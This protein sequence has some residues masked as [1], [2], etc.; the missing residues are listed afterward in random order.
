MKVKTIIPKSEARK[1][2]LQRSGEFSHEDARRKTQA[3]IERLSTLDDFIHA[4][5]V[6]THISRNNWEIDTRRLIDYIMGQGKSVV[7]PK[8][9]L[10]SGTLQRFYFTGWDN[11]VKNADGYLEPKIGLNE[12]NSDVDLFIVPALAISSLGQRVGHGK[13]LYNNVIRNVYATKIVLAYEFQVFDAIESNP[14]DVL[15]DK[16]V[17]ERRVIN[18]RDIK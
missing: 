2:V 14:G 13:G 18:T 10:I 16:I 11:L 7:I 17:T 6:H 12:D 1:I 5:I 4:K 15:I 8:I 3:I 9:N